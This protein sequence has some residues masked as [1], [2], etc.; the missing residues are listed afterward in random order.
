M[1]R[2]KRDVVEGL[3]ILWCIELRWATARWWTDPALVRVVAS[4]L[5][6]TARWPELAF[7]GAE[8]RKVEPI[9]TLADVVRVIGAPGVHRFAHAGTR[10]AMDDDECD[11][12]VDVGVAP[13]V[14]KIASVVRGDVLERLGPVVLDDLVQAVGRIRGELDGHIWL[15][16]MHAR[17]TA[18]GALL[19]PREVPALA[20]DSATPLEAIVDVVDIASPGEGMSDALRQHAHLVATAAVPDTAKR[21][22]LG[23]LVVMRWIYDPRSPQA[24]CEAAARRA[25]WLAAHWSAT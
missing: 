11:A 13:H 17:P 24:V 10:Q 16:E 4:A 6:T 14:L 1:T 19:Y 7:V 20:R 23:R 8:G 12:W 9:G 21:R 5:T 18:T 3:Q 25:A 22:R 2:S 15:L